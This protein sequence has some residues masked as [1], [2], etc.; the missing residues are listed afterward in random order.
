MSNPELLAGDT[1][2][3][4]AV[5]APSTPAMLDPK[6]HVRISL[7]SQ[8][9]SNQAR[10]TTPAYPSSSTPAISSGAAT[11]L[12]K[13]SPALPTS[14]S[15]LALSSTSSSTGSSPAT[16]P[17]PSTT[18]STSF[19]TSD[20]KAL[21]AM[22]LATPRS[23]MV[24]G[25]P[26]TAPTAVALAKPVAL[27]EDGVLLHVP[28]LPDAFPWQLPGENVV[29]ECPNVLLLPEVSYL[30][31][32]QG[33]LVITNYQLVFIPGEQTFSSHAIEVLARLL[34]GCLLPPNCSLTT[35]P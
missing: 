11:S 35:P 25:S 2:P 12:T 3:P 21:P 23:P 34:S 7:L 13:S 1:E 4:T 24:G 8:S 10:A 30:P 19:I 28:G 27:N 9:L 26:P 14:L 16:S 32:I 33:S 31:T 29:L 22:S 15:K 17:K 20:F 6:K 5:A 18:K